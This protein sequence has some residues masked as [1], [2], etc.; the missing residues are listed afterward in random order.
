MGQAAEAAEADG[1]AEARA[2]KRF[3]R[4]VQTGRMEEIREAAGLTQS[5]V[6]RAL[7]V[8]Q[9]TVWRWEAGER[10]P[11]PRHALAVLELLDE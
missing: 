11:R 9:S 2:M 1:L 6:A 10:R 3:H 5:D 7:G 4:L 8:E